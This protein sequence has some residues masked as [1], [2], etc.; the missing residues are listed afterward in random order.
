MAFP[1]PWQHESQ[2]IRLSHDLLKSGLAS[3]IEF[4][5][6]EPVKILIGYFQ[7]TR[8]IWLQPP[9]LE[10]D[11]NAAERG[12]VEPLITNAA[13]ISELPAVNIYAM[14]FDKGRHK[15]DVHG[16]GSFVVLGIIPQSADVTKRDA[17]R[18][19]GGS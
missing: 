11:A 14:K 3:P 5:T 8:D 15:L 7:S 9:T 12:D 10:T 4:E 1:V 6:S 13:T 18:A 16:K 17:K 2:G 19:G